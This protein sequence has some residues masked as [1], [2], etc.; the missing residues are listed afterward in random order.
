MN[1]LDFLETVDLFKGMG[2]NQIEAIQPCCE[3]AEFKRGERIF[4]AGE[5]AG[6]L[7]VVMEGNVEL[8]EE[9]RE[10]KV[11]DAP[12]ISNL[13]EGHAFGWST[14]ASPYKYYLSAYSASRTCKVLKMERERFTKL[15]EADPG[16]GYP[17][18][19]K[20]LTLIGRRFDE[21][22]EKVIKRLGQDMI[23][24]W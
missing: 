16:I 13:S 18:M 24:D 14:L 9:A 17:V 12:V 22:E 7:Y 1:I 21:L 4:C 20:I 11:Q 2:D 10:G 3:R 19:T 23:N 5:D 6:F 8:R 15:I